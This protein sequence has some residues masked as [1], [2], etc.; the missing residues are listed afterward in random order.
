MDNNVIRIVTRYSCWACTSFVDLL[1]YAFLNVSIYGCRATRGI[2]HWNR[3]YIKS[4]CGVPRRTSQRG[5][6]MTFK[7][8]VLKNAVSEYA[9]SAFSVSNEI[10]F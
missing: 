10:N 6:Y 2:P 9:V 7:V 4:K 5:F 3:Q 1:D 8:S